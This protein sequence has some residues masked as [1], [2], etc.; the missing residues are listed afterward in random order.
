MS[1]Q[2]RHDAWQA[3]ENYDRYMGRWS[4][5]L[6]PH[7]V[8]WLNPL[9]GF[10]WLD[11]GCGTGALTEAL[12]GAAVPVSIVAIDPSEGLLEQARRISARRGASPSAPPRG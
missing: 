11:I 2:T 4:R 9:P 7:V 8:D 12:L 5:A 3:G 6:A 1:D 10:E